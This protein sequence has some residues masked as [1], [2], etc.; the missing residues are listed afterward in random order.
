MAK[1]Q[2]R[3]E[4]LGTAVMHRA[5][6]ERVGYLRGLLHAFMGRPMAALP[7]YSSPTSGYNAAT[8][9]RRTMQIG[10]TYRGVNSLALA[11]GALMLART[12]KSVMENP[13]AANGITSFIAEVIG[14]GIR[15]HSKHSDPTIRKTLEKEFSLWTKQSSAARRIGGDGKPDSLHD[16]FGQQ[17]LVCRNVVEAGEAFARL[18]PRLASDL[19]PSGLRVPLQ[20][21]LIEPEQLAFWR[22][23]GDMPAGAIAAGN[24]VRASIEF[25]Q[26]HQRVAYHFYREHPGDSTIW[27]NA[28]EVVRVPSQNVLHVMEFIRG[29]QIR[30][31]TSLAPILIQLGDLDDY[32]D[33]ERLRQKLG[34]Y[35]FAWKK[36][37]TPDDP[38]LNNVGTTVGNDVAPEGTSYVESQPGT[39]T[40][41][42][43]NAGEEMGFYAHPG[44]ENTYEVFMRVQRQT[45]ATI[46]KVTYEMLTGDM[47]QVNYS[48]ARVRLIA[49]RRIWEQFQAAIMIHQFCR[50]VWR[51]WLDAAALVGVIDATDYAKHPEEYLNVEWS[52]QPWDWVDPKSDVD[53]VRMQIE[54]CLTSREAEVAKRGQDAEEVDAAIAR[55]HEREQ[56]MGIS[57][58]YGASRVT[59]TVPPGGH[60][61][62][63]MDG[64]DG[65]PAPKKQPVPI[66]PAGGKKQ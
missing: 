24:L 26:I 58:V 1:V 22:M 53:S 38:Q 6:P 48:S 21:D 32:D 10:T 33:A 12:R 3:S 43:T 28:Y 47:N 25:D 62:P 20:I 44:V 11:D 63:L 66:A 23:T 15:P 52:G 39:V 9:G 46:L 8:M 4:R 37:L 56:R 31:I 42:D 65:G 61:E 19:S 30:G 40:V 13:L 2:L 45:I 41:I 27:P 36:T 18:R 7:Y 50:P 35:L 51:A 60:E 34:A 49:L 5:E 17:M 64:P 29:N 16:F 59:E 14:T 55:D 57:P 54:S